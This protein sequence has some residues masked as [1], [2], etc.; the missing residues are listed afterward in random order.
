VAC[1][2]RGLNYIQPMNADCYRIYYKCDEIK[3]LCKNCI[4]T[5]RKCDFLV[6]TFENKRTSMLGQELYPGRPAIPPKRQQKKPPPTLIKLRMLIP[7]AFLSLC[8]LSC[9]ES[10]HFSYFRT[11]CATTFSR[12]F[13]DSIWKTLIL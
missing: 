3:P 1:H 13:H 8:S 10:S 2:S 9:A 5:S 4:N 11:V 12:Y 7:T 6:L